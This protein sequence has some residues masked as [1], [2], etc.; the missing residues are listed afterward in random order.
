MYDFYCKAELEPDH[1]V[2]GSVIM[3]GSGRVSGQSYLLTDP[4]SWP[5]FWE[6]NRMIQ[7]L[8]LCWEHMNETHERIVQSR[9]SMNTHVQV[10]Q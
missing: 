6:N 8:F 3:S 7:Q 4:V 10:S 1:W 9:G 5:G 2:T